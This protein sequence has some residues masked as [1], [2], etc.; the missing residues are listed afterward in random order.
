[1]GAVLSPLI[2]IVASSPQIK[3][4]MDEM[5][6]VVP[7]GSKNAYSALA[8]AVKILFPLENQNDK[9]MVD[10]LMSKLETYSISTGLKFNAS[11]SQLLR[12]GPKQLECQ[13]MLMG[14]PIPEVKTMKDLGCVFSKNYNFVP[15]IATRL[16]KARS[17]IQIIKHNL[18]LRTPEAMKI[19]FQAYFQSVILYSSEVW[20]NLQD[21]MLSKL[22]NVD[23]EFWSLLPKSMEKPKCLNSVQ[24]ALKTNLMIFFKHKHRLMK[25]TFASDFSKIGDKYETRANAR[26]DLK[27]KKCKMQATNNEFVNVTTKLF[28]LMDPIKRSS[29][30]LT[31]FEKEAIRM[32][33][34]NF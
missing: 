33:C 1:M 6:N 4:I 24:L 9:T 29:K 25:T 2:F 23:S 30:L 34:C 27:T 26:N 3:A 8:F 22:Y 31:V 11:K 7:L 18:L 20:V 19:I 12:L 10:L 17:V 28:N 21:R 14:N 5:N 13:L 15:M 32:L 16:A